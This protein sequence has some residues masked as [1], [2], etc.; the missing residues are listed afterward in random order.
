M[1]QALHAVIMALRFNQTL[2]KITLAYLPDLSAENCMEL[3]NA[4]INNP[5]IKIQMLDFQGTSIRFFVS[6]F[7]FSFFPFIY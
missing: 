5:H 1:D 4:V 7:F 3:R 6:S 2:T